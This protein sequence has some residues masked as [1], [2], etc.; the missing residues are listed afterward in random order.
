MQADA[1]LLK[2]KRNTVVEWT[3]VECTI[4]EWAIVIIKTSLTKISYQRLL[5]LSDNRA[6][7]ARYNRL[8]AALL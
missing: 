6:V 2:P 3:I 8:V 4:V 7:M 5:T 1:M